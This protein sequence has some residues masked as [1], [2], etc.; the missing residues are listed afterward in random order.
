MIGNY[1]RATDETDR[2]QLFE[3]IQQHSCDFNFN[4]SEMGQVGGPHL[5]G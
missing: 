3:A 2:E 5:R 4:L 1:R